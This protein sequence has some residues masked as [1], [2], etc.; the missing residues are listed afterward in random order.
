[1]SGVRLGLSAGAT[2]SRRLGGG[3][4]PERTKGHAWRACR[5]QPLAGSNPAATARRRMRNQPSGGPPSG[6]TL[7]RKWSGDLF[8]VLENPAHVVERLP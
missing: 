3:G 7:R 2:R 4:L 5:G 8:G 1:M 6:A